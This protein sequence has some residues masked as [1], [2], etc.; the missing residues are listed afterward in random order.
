MFRSDNPT[1]L[2]FIKYL[3]IVAVSLSALLIT[4]FIIGSIYYK[5]IE[6]DKENKV[7]EVSEYE[8]RNN[9]YIQKEFKDISESKINIIKNAETNQ[10]FMNDFV[11]EKD[12]KRINLNGNSNEPFIYRVVEIYHNQEAKDF[13]NLS[14]GIINLTNKNLI[15][16]YDRSYLEDVDGNLYSYLKETEEE[17]E[18]L[19]GSSGKDFSITF[20]TEKE[21]DLD[22]V[23]IHLE[24]KNKVTKESEIKLNIERN[25]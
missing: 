7:L 22:K 10:I 15:L 8:N 16:D 6:E 21:L 14:I 2:P 13:V 1:D 25:M 4:L 24:F 3:L 17:F 5:G 11:R 18:N 20:N 12:Y 23:K 9:D 19:N